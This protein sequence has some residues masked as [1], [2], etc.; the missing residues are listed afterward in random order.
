MKFN[1]KYLVVSTYFT[2]IDLYSLTSNQLLYQYYGHTCSVSCF[3]FNDKLSL[4]VSGSSD[5]TIKYWSI[6]VNSCT[7][8]NN[9]NLLIKSEINLIWPVKVQIV[10][11]ETENDY[12]VM[13]LCANA[14]LYLCYVQ[15]VDDEFRNE[16][17]QINVFKFAFNLIISDTYKCLLSVFND[18]TTNDL[19]DVLNL[20]DDQQNQ[21]LILSNKSY[22]SYDMNKKSVTLFLI[23]DKNAFRMKKISIKK[24]LLRKNLE[25]KEF[26][27]SK[28]EFDESYFEFL[29]KRS[30]KSF[31][32]NQLE[33]IAFGYK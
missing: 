15:K 9:K 10:N 23:T 5:N 20:I 26:E 33:I 16:N 11:Y 8:S 27:V 19:D 31:D 7:D 2:K 14:F 4:L 6:N 17:D 12:L 24:W 18:I 13:A 3:D 21:N 25:S 29:N 32:I 30:F 28:C 1:D 22:I